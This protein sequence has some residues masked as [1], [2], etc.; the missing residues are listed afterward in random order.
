M[1]EVEH[2]ETRSLISADKVA[3][4]SVYNTAGDKN[5]TVANVMID[6]RG[7]NVAYAVMSFGSF[8]SIGE[9]HHPLPW[10]KLL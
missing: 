6:K 5:G 3:N 1:S 2:D 10:S 9:N 8:L 4:T 7:G